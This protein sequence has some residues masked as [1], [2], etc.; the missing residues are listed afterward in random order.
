MRK[1]NKGKALSRP[2]SQK[3]ALLK[4]MAGSLFIHGKIET[5]QVK[6]RELKPV[7]EKFITRAKEANMADRR[8]LARS[9]S[10]VILKKLIDEVAPSFKTRKGGYTRIIKLG[11]RKSDG[12]SMVIVE[13]VK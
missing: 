12:T 1:R 8:L 13:L 10:P 11:R 2:K 6:A 3:E 4:S 5:T 7:A 9:F